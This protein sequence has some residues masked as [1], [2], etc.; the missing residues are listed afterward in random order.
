[1]ARTRGGKRL[2]SKTQDP[3]VAQDS[4][5]HVKTVQPSKDKSKLPYVCYTCSKEYVLRDSFLAHIVTHTKEKL[6]NIKPKR[7]HRIKPPSS[8]PSSTSSS[9]VWEEVEDISLTVPSTREK[10]QGRKL[11]AQETELE[12]S[13]ENPS[14]NFPSPPSTP[15]TS[16]TLD[17]H[18]REFGVS[19]SSSLSS[20]PSGPKSSFLSFPSPPTTSDRSDTPNIMDTHEDKRQFH[21]TSSSSLSSD[22]LS[23]FRKRP[24]NTSSA[25]LKSATGKPAV[26]TQMT[27]PAPSHLKVRKTQTSYIQEKNTEEPTIV[28]SDD[29]EELMTEKIPGAI[30][31]S[32]RTTPLSQL[33]VT[34]F[35]IGEK[36]QDYSTS[37]VYTTPLK[38]TNVS[39]EDSVTAGN[40]F[41]S[42]MNDV[43]QSNTNVIV[44]DD[45]EPSPPWRPE[46]VKKNSVTKRLF[47]NFPIRQNKITNGGFNLKSREELLQNNE[48]HNMLRRLGPGITVTKTTSENS[49]KTNSDT[50]YKEETKEAMDKIRKLGPAISFSR[51]K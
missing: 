27:I 25:G 17:T 40:V 36:E 23:L 20:S 12:I 8:S 37:A 48:S 28:I 46:S 18:E 7:Q 42:Y 38:A 4:T 1:M 10:V 32:S 31:T 26:V 51:A 9:A 39:Y 3:A 19:S 11:T 24:A 13:L 16:S 30:G 35:E 29:E 34:S 33:D 45:D 41:H 21:Q 44:S 47:S 14:S 5:Q 50:F 6:K 15:V 2:N 43:S 49:T 22:I